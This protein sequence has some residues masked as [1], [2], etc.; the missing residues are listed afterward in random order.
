MR[1]L[2]IQRREQAAWGDPMVVIVAIALAGLGLINVYASTGVHAGSAFLSRQATGLALGLVVTLLV[3]RLPLAWMERLVWVGIIGLCILLLL[4]LFTP[5]GVMKNG[6]RRSMNL[7]AFFL[8]PAELAKPALLLWTA[9]F[10]SLPRAWTR[11]DGVIFSAGVVVPLALI[12]GTKDLG[13]PVV[14]AAGLFTVWFL[15][16]APWRF[17]LPTLAAGAGIVWVLIATAGHRLRYVRAWMDPYCSG[18]PSS[19][20]RIAHR[21]C[22]DETNALRQSYQAIADGG[23]LG[24]PLGGGQGPLH[25]MEGHNDFIGALVAEQFG[26]VGLI[27]VAALFTI[28]LV[29]GLRISARAPSRFA[30][31]VVSGAASLNFIQAAVHLAVVSGTIPP[32]GLTL[33]L[34]SAGNSSMLATACLIGFILNIAR[35]Q[36]DPVEGRSSQ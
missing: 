29:R 1:S 23:L 14:L 28:L 13:T 34:V 11:R 25:V 9:Y 36:A 24:T 35:H 7:G 12:V 17:M 32:K 2:E 21:A 20:D 26:L 15:S 8:M 18:R 3:T 4:T 30:G 27:G 31:L 22:L 5:L 10:F 19:G 6:A 16:G 33:P